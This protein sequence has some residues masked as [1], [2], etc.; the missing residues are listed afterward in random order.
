MRGGSVVRILK[1]RSLV[2]RGPW[3]RVRPVGRCGRVHRILQV[4]HLHEIGR[5]RL[6][7]W[8]LIALIFS[9]FS[10]TNNSTGVTNGGSSRANWAARSGLTWRGLLAYMTKPMASAPAATASRTSSSRVNP[11]I[12]MRVWWG[13]V[14]GLARAD[15]C[16]LGGLGFKANRGN[17]AKGA[18]MC[19]RC[20][21]RM[22]LSGQRQG[23]SQ[24]AGCQRAIA[25]WVRRWGP[26]NTGHRA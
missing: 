9:D 17:V 15:M 1:G 18:G 11:Q 26:G 10:F 3:A 2:R 8:A 14:V 22:K 13:R 6:I 7:L 25:S 12:L 24:T 19:A 4:I 21:W 20:R 16:D 5:C 23:A